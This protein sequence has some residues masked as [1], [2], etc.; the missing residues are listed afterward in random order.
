MKKFPDHKFHEVKR[1]A[2]SEKPPTGE[3]ENGLYS[4]L[5][6]K[7]GTPARVV[8]AYDIFTH[9]FKREVMESF[10]LCG[11][12]PSE[13]NEILGV[14]SDIT[15][16]YIGLFFDTSVFENQL[17][18]LDYA[19]EYKTSTFGSTLKR[20]AVDLGKECLKVR[21]SHGT[22]VVDTGIVQKSVRSTAYLMAQLAHVNPADSSIANAALRWAQVGLKAVADDVK[23]ESGGV[24][25]LQ[26]ALE[27]RNETTDE[28]KS[29]IPVDEILH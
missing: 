13:I 4:L 9:E 17:D 25:D 11:A 22:Y 14:S 21:M 6:G 10:L 12:T 7:K 2:E 29:G 16:A 20:F 3:L 19:Y 26:F 27:T 23:E 18:N 24:A 8:S 1:A 28:E 5:L 15:E